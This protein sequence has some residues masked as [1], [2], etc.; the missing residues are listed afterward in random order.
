METHIRSARVL[1]PD[2][3]VADTT[4]TIAEG[5]IAA[6]GER[7]SGRAIKAGDLSLLPRIVSTLVAGRIVHAGRELASGLAA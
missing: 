5:R 2:S 1:M 7:P 3:T 4:A 6:P